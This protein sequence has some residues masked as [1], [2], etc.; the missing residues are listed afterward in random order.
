[1]YR[2][3]RNNARLF[4]V[5]DF[6]TNVKPGCDFLQYLSVIITYLVISTLHRLGYGRLALLVQFLLSKGGEVPVF[7]AHD[8]GEHLN[9]G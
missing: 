2:I 5:T 1:M 9:S 4:T 6:S 3:G 8:W 7:N